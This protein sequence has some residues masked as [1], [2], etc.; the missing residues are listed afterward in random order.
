MKIGLLLKKPESVFSNGCIQQSLFLKHV[1]TRC[2]YD[3]H[4]YTIEHDFNTF[5]YSDEKII[6]TDPSFDFSDV[7]ILILASLT[8][9]YAGNKEYIENLKSFEHLK[10]VNFICGNV[11]ILHQEEFVFDKHHIIHHYIVDYYHETWI[12]EMYESTK[13]YLQLLTKRP[14]YVTSYIWGPD[15]IQ[16]YISEKELGSVYDAIHK[17]DTSK[18]NLLIFE[19]NMSV[20]KN[21]LIPLVIAE[22]YYVTH[23]DNVNKVYVFCADKISNDSKNAQFFASLEIVRDKR[24]E[25]YGRIVMPHIVSKIRES[26]KYINIVL[27]HNVM[28]KLNFIHLELFYLGIPI[29]HNCEPYE[30]NGLYYKDGNETKAVQLIEDI[31]TDFN[32]ETYKTVTSSIIDKYHYTNNKVISS[33]TNVC[34]TYEKKLG[35]DAQNKKHQKMNQYDD[36]TQIKYSPTIIYK[37]T[38]YLIYIDNTIDDG[39]FINEL[40]KIKM[41]HDMMDIEIVYKNDIPFHK[42]PFFLTLNIQ[43]IHVNDIY[44]SKPNETTEFEFV[45]DMCSFK[46]LFILDIGKNTVQLIER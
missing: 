19:P 42:L 5:E 31:R 3:V 7:D 29:I 26:N 24:L 4:F 9:T 20:H 17:N 46:H 35:I 38:G 44:Q 39:Q 23:K 8:L 43:Q 16:K 22:N 6:F 40:N 11:Y 28:N 15:I 30:S 32:V 33:Y 1:L 36:N 27:S 41:K 45:V 10:I 14:V 37:G 18:V 34:K 12:L 21:S 25:I 2:G 13:E